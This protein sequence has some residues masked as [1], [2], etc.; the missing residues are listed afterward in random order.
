MDRDGKALHEFMR[1]RGRVWAKRSSDDSRFTAT[2]LTIRLTAVEGAGADDGAN[3]AA[4]TSK[5][6]KL[7]SV[8]K[9]STYDE[10]SCDEDEAEPEG[11]GKQPAEP[12]VQTVR[13]LANSH[14]LDR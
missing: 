2:S 14:R 4:S 5:K 9:S 13:P 3:E 12:V 1:E 7:R 10:R 8:G 6:R 11:K